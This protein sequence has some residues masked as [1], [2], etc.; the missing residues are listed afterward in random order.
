MET[1]GRY[2]TSCKLKRAATVSSARIAGKNMAESFGNRNFWSS[3]TAGVYLDKSY[4]IIH[5]SLTK[6]SETVSWSAIR[7]FHKEVRGWQDIG[8]HAGIEK[9]GGDY[10]ILMGRFFAEVGAHTKE[11]MMNSRGIGICCVG[12]FDA[13]P[14]PEEMLVKLVKFVNWIRRL[15]DIDAQHVLGHGEVQAMARVPEPKSC[16]GKMFNMEKLR[17]RL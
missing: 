7:R 15:Y 3:G 12:N 5:H 2:S 9:I 1:P 14:P 6:D 16:P 4:I 11:L 10:E 13:E 17:G 8:Y